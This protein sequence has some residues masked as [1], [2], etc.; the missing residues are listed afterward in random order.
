MFNTVK[1][2][3]Q[4]VQGSGRDAK[5]YAHA[6]NVCVTFFLAQVKSVY[7]FCYS[8]NKVGNVAI[9]CFLVAY[10]VTFRKFL[11][12]FCNIWIIWAF[13]AVLSRIY[14][15]RNSHTFFLGKTILAPTLFV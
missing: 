12:I 1:S 4:Q 11:C 13:Y 3:V 2:Q 15:C 8:V 10:F 14:F 9:W 5:T 7:I 6:N